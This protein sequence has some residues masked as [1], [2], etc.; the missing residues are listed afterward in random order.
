MKT[1]TLPSNR[2]LLLIKK[3]KMATISELKNALGSNSAMTVFRKL[4]ELDYITSCSH[5]GKYY[6]LK[7][8]AKFNHMGL[9]IHNSVL[10]SSYGTLKETDKKFIDYLE[11]YHG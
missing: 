7:R 2:L 8:I 3:Q 4:R 10:F 1:V 11:I 5:R 6:S 9:W